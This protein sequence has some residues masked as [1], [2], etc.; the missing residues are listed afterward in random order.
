MIILIIFKKHFLSGNERY[1][2]FLIAFLYCKSYCNSDFPKP[3]NRN[4]NYNIYSDNQ[5]DS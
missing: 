3:I 1:R 5:L 2:I 4:Y